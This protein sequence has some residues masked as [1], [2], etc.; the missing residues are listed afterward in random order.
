MRK[1]GLRKDY[2]CWVVRFKMNRKVLQRSFQSRQ[3]AEKVLA[4]LEGWREVQRAQEFLREAIE[5]GVMNAEQREIFEKY[6]TK[7]V[8]DL[9]EGQKIQIN[10]FLSDYKRAIKLITCKNCGKKECRSYGHDLCCKCYNKEYY[11]TGRRKSG[12][13]GVRGRSA[14]DVVEGSVPTENAD[15]PHEEGKDG[16]LIR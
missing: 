6:I 12:P 16:Q 15:T 8:C 4:L 2:N 1:M 7:M 3:L 13:K 10:N 11:E 5:N 9:T 14:A